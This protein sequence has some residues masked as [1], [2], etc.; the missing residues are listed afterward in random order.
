ME[1][2]LV[3][4]HMKSPVEAIESTKT[5]RQA[6]SLMTSHKFGSLLVIHEGKLGIITERDLVYAL[7]EFGEN[8]SIAHHVSM[9]LIKI[10]QNEDIIAAASIMLNKKIRRLAVTGEDGKITGIINMRDIVDEL[11]HKLIERS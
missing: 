11:Q 5:I 7:A 4:D 1:K 6:A 9:P 2:I 8:S 3:K 10:D